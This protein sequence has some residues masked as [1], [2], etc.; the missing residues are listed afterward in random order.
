VLS[1]EEYTRLLPNLAPHLEAIV[2]AGFYTGMRKGELVNLTRE[3]IDVQSRMIRLEGKDTKEG[4][5]KIIPIC[6]TL[7]EILNRLP[8]ALHVPHLF[9]FNTKPVC[10]IRTGLKRACQK[11]DIPYGQDVKNGFIFRDLRRTVKTNMAR[12]GVSKVFRDTILGHSLKGMD[13][14]YMAPS[15]DD[16][17]QAMDRYETWVNSQLQNVT[18]NVTQKAKG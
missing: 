3:K 13:A 16:L 8:R 12:A 10:D 18:Q 7:W 1:F 2:A 4:R 17:H 6:N 15:E 9:L 11:A 5:P 14:Y